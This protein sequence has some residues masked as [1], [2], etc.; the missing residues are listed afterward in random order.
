MLVDTGAD[1][2]MVAARVVEEA[3]LDP[4]SKVPV[5]CVHGDVCLY[6]TAE[7][8]LASGSWRR[9][10]QVAVAPNLPVAVLLIFIK[11]SPVEYQLD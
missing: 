7:V 3:L 6:P 1:R 8:E 2:T 5:L 11:R 4:E 10:A 9:K